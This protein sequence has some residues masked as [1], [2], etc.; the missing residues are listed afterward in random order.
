MSDGAWTQDRLDALLEAFLDLSLPS[1][2][3][4]HQAHLLVGAMLARRT[5][6]AELLPFLRRAISA[7]N[8]ASGAQNTETAGYHESITAF[9]AAVL[10]AFA[11]A[12]VDLPM[13]EAARRLL[14]SHLADRQIVTRAYDPATL[15]TVR[16]RLAL[17]PWDRGDF[18]P[19]TLVAEALADV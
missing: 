7:Y 13:T 9:Y 1:E 8:L 4:T 19:E 3:W 16:G 2:Q 5:P 15:K 18:N 10:A 11:R 14:A 17:A 6:E 12:T